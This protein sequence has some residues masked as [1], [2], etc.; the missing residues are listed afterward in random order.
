M[1]G[2]SP[3]GG[4]AGC[5]RRGSPLLEEP[6]TDPL[7]LDVLPPETRWLADR[8]EFLS[9]L[10]RG[11]MAVVY[12]A[13]ERDSGRQVAIKLIHGRYTG[14]ADAVRRFAREAQTVA[15]L[16]HPNVVRTLE[17]VEHGGAIA[18][19]HAYAH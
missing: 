4:H 17:V 13:R 15:A 6:S 1:T 11:G 19:V 9:E 5:L 16:R 8:Y 10:G 12:L 14:D 3:G 7:T 18:I 2:P